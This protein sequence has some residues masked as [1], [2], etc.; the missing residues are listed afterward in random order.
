MSEK[1]LIIFVKNLEPGKVK[2]R[3]SKAIGNDKALEIYGKLLGHTRKLA[4]SVDCER[5][6]FYWPL[7]IEEDEWA[8][9]TFHKRLQRGHDLGEKMQ[10]AF[11]EI[12][13]KHDKVVIIGSDS[14]EMTKG[15]VESAFYELDENDVVIGPARDGGYYLLGM[16]DLQLFLFQDMPWS[17]EQLL[18]E[19]IIKTQDRGLTYALLRTRSDVDFIED[20]EASKHLIK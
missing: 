2:T 11:E 7:L 9:D 5:Y 13:Q 12:L 10:N 16:N 3:I 20:W 6:V 15:D 4:A 17:E 1:A 8:N 19:S 14:A 18:E